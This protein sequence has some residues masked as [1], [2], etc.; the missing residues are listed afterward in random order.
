MCT[1]VLSN[2]LAIVHCSSLHHPNIVQLMGIAFEGGNILIVM[3]FMVNGS[4][5]DL[6]SDPQFKVDWKFRISA[7][8]A[9]LFLHQSA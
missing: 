7:V 4:V 5:K 1:S 3:E 6:L 9:L 2:D 8:S